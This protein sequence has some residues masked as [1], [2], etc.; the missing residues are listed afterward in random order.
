MALGK[1]LSELLHERN[2]TVK[3][4][5][6]RI[7][8]APTTLYSFIRR[9]SKTGKLN[10]IDKIARGLGM[11]IEDFL[12]LT[13]DTGEKHDIDGIE[14]RCQND[15]FIPQKETSNR[16]SQEDTIQLTSKNQ[17]INISQEALDN[18]RKFDEVANIALKK[19]KSDNDYSEEERQ[20]ISAYQDHISSE[21]YRQQMKE[22]REKLLKAKESLIETYSSLNAED[23]AKV[24]EYAEMLAK[25]RKE[26]DDHT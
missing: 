20:K 9:D 14:Q 21:E 10:L 19:H 11:S 24:E 6:D 16:M 12:M 18:A 25:F 23:R 5:A 17:S 15:S 22:H 7:G 26:D 1:K 8:V 3:E 2:I 13:S 4:F